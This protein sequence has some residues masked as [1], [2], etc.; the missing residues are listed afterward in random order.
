MLPKT[1]EGSSKPA[2]SSPPPAPAPAKKSEPA[3][4]TG[5]EKGSSDGFGAPIRRPS[6]SGPASPDASTSETARSAPVDR[7]SGA[8]AAPTSTT[9]AASGTQSL[10]S[11]SKVQQG[12]KLI[13]DATDLAAEKRLMREMGSVRQTASPQPADP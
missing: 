6:G 13:D 7:K 11:A 9:Q 5:F 1:G 10:S 2:A 8:G 12:S 4:K 3:P